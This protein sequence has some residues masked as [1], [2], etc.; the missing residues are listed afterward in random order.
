VL[1]P[2]ENIITAS[3]K[4]PKPNMLHLALGHTPAAFWVIAGP[5]GPVAL[6]LS[7][8]FAGHG[9]NI[10]E[11]ADWAGVAVGPIELRVDPSSAHSGEGSRQWAL[12]ASDGTLQVPV[13]IK[14]SMGFGETVWVPLQEIST[15]ANLTVYFP[16]WSLGLQ[17][18]GEWTELV[19]VSNGNLDGWILPKKEE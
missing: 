8:Q 10:T 9:F 12:R 14:P 11:P 7:G 16:Q 3:F 6:M 18:G 19:S 13:T 1:I 17:I 5:D 4:E 2:V 15:I